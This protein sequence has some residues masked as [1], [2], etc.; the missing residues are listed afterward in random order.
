MT[1]LVPLYCR[2]VILFHHEGGVDIGDVESKAARSARYS[3]YIYEITLV[4]SRFPVKKKS[5]S[6]GEKNEGKGL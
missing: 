1:V 4:H 6:C 3:E 2:D 5:L